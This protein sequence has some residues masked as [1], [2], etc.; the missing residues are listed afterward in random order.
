[1]SFEEKVI[2]SVKKK[3]T[4]SV[5]ADPVAN[6]LDPTLEKS[7]TLSLEKTAGHKTYHT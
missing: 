4:K 1:M 7:T 6:D 3:R 5:V 2:I